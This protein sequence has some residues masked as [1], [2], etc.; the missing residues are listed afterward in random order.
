MSFKSGAQ[1]RAVIE[2]HQGCIANSACGISRA[3][4]AHIATRTRHVQSVRASGCVLTW[5]YSRR[6]AEQ[7]AELRL[8]GQL[9]R[10]Q[11]VA[12]DAGN[13]QGKILVP[14]RRLTMLVPSDSVSSDQNA[15]HARNGPLQEHVLDVID[16]VRQPTFA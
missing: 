16:T 13:H 6:A 4:I 15:P 7:C 1:S 10:H 12:L 11:W 2:K 5:P 3:P 9:L 8:L 14:R